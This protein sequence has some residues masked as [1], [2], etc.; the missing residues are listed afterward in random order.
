VCLR[1]QAAVAANI[2]SKKQKPNLFAAPGFGFIETWV[3]T[4]EELF[5]SSPDSRRWTL[6]LCRAQVLGLLLVGS[7]VFALAPTKSR[8]WV[9]RPFQHTIAFEPITDQPKQPVSFIGRTTGH[10]V[11]L[12]SKEVT[13]SSNARHGG[14][15]CGADSTVFKGMRS[16]LVSERTSC[17]R[18]S[19]PSFT[20]LRLLGVSSEINPEGREPLHSYNNYLIGNDP[21]RWTTHVPQFAEV[22][23]PS[24]YSGIDLVYYGNDGKLEY[25]FVVA[26]HANPDQIR[27]AIRTSTS[28]SF[29]R[30]NDAGDLVI[31]GDGRRRQSSRVGP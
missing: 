25:D 18:R 22:W 20:R 12:T 3:R 29:V 27:F 2:G 21:K 26:P 16:S 8:S 6:N 11:S 5:R 28:H 23:Y 10:R 4:A 15:T 31:P 1:R 13:F 17:V 24:T 19:A 30:V 9:P 14:K 7:S